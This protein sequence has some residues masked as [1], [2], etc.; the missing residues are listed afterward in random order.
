MQEE[1]VDYV[2]KFGE[3]VHTTSNK[4]VDCIIYYLTGFISNKLFNLS[5]CDV[6]RLELYN[7]CLN[8]NTPSKL[9]AVKNKGYLNYA[10]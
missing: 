10:S 5:N 9:V 1:D 4:T 8:P 6:C 3:V 2:D 7:K